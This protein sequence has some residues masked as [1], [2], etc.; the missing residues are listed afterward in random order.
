MTS[1]MMEFTKWHTEHCQN[2]LIQRWQSG[3]YL[4]IVNMHTKA[5]HLLKLLIQKWHSGQDL[6]IV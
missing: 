5:K 4:S 6:G 1:V 3:Q 2:L